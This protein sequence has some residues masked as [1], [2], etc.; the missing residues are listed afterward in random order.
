MPASPRA[1]RRGHVVEPAVAVQPLAAGVSRRPSRLSL[2]G[3]GR[4]AAGDLA[5]PTAHTTP[6]QPSTEKLSGD[7]RPPTAVCVAKSPA[8]ALAG[9]HQSLCPRPAWPGGG[10]RPGSAFGGIAQGQSTSCGGALRGSARVCAA[11][12]RSGRPE[13][14]ATARPKKISSH[15]PAAY[16]L[17]THGGERAGT[18]RG[19]GDRGDGRRLEERGAAR[20][21]PR[22]PTN[23]STTRP[24]CVP[25]AHA[26]PRAPPPGR[27]AQQP[28]S[29]PRVS[30]GHSPPAGKG[31]RT[32]PELRWPS[33][34]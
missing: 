8:V 3:G 12:L 18:A 25:S 21:G 9:S 5:N 13:T 7:R 23:N 1:A 28:L 11:L 27:G 26:P 15:R 17:P 20:R 31:E 4:Q 30:T 10:R 32:D 2:R 24:P 14:L 22:R 29:A 6:R 19:G 33:S 16:R 34:S